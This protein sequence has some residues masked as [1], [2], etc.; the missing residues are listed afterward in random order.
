VRRLLFAIAFVLLA[1]SLAFAE[2]AKLDK[3]YKCVGVQ[4]NKEYKTDLTIEVKDGNVYLAW[5]NGKMLGLGVR[6]GDTIAIA[7]VVPANGGVGVL[8]YK[9]ED[10]ELHGRWTF[11]GGIFTETCVPSG[12][13]R[14]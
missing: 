2:Q 12:T 4:D 6:T 7:L 11:S 9:M 1:I 5:D 13:I 14:A 3:N 8:L 10:G